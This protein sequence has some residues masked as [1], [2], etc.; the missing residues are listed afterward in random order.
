MHGQNWG[1]NG[2][3][4][5]KNSLILRLCMTDYPFVHDKAIR[6]AKTSFIYNKTVSSLCLIF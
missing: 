1:R 4:L 2:V 3:H 6:G 5:Y